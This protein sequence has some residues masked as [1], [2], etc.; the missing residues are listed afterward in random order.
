MACAQQVA[1]LA[2]GTVSD[3]GDGLVGKLGHAIRGCDMPSVLER[4]D[5]CDVFFRVEGQLI[6]AVGAML[7]SVRED[8]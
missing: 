2:L 8:R 1:L 5:L 3:L 4:D 7:I 6:G